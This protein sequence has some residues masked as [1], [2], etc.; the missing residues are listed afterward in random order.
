[1]TGDLTFITNKVTNVLIVPTIYIKSEGD[2][3]F[4]WV[5]D[6]SNEKKAYV[7]VGLET[8]DK[9]EIKTG[10]KEGQEIINRK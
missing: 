10:L 4:V 9:T 6:G 5:K 2:K 8:D 7:T 3:K 1:M